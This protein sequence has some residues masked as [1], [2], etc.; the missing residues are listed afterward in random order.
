MN[1]I[2]LPEILFDIGAL[3]FSHETEEAPEGI[4][5][6]LFD[7]TKED[8][9]LE[10]ALPAPPPPPEDDFL[11][12]DFPVENYRSPTLEAIVEAHRKNLK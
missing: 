7:L 6:I 1:V 8:P 10:E 11:G 3:N 4:C 2:I 5:P 12:P 9:E